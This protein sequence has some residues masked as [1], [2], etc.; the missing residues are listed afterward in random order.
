MA[1]ANTSAPHDVIDMHTGYRP[2]VGASFSDALSAADRYNAGY[3]PMRFCSVETS[4]IPAGF[5][6]LRSDEPITCGLFVVNLNPEEDQDEHCEERI[7]PP[8]TLGEIVGLNHVNESGVSTWD[9][10]FKST[11]AWICPDDHELRNPGEFVLYVKA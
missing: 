9:L 6:P 11:G 4:L 3:R 10:V 1:T 2:V 7:T 5:R 8:R